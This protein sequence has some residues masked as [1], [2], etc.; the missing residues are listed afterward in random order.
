MDFPLG[1]STHDSFQ[2]STSRDIGLLAALLDKPENRQ[3]AVVATRIHF[4]NFDGVG[5]H[6]S[7]LRDRIRTEGYKRAIEAVVKPGDRV[8][9]FGCGTG[10]LSFFASRAGAEVVYAID[11]SRMIRNAQA[12][13][14]ANGITNIRF[15]KG[16]AETVVLPEKVDVIVSETM[17]EFLLSEHGL[18][19]LFS[20]RNKWLKPGGIVIPARVRL[21]V[22]LVGDP[23]VVEER[24]VFRNRPYGVDYSTVADWPFH[25][26]AIASLS[27]EQLLFES[28]ELA[29]LDFGTLDAAPTLLTGRITPSR[30]VEAYALCGWFDAALTEGIEVGTG[31]HDPK[32]SWS[33]MVFPLERPFRARG[34]CP[35]TMTFR[36]QRHA[37]SDSTLW[38][39]SIEDS[40]DKI[41]MD[42]IVL[43]AWHRR[44]LADGWLE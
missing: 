37:A 26:T 3:T 35:I 10:I 28:I 8:L 42:E 16:E 44:P 18:A 23:H 25:E 40:A 4:M 6:V 41:E 11:R 19:P 36:P 17:G 38:K 21:H 24:G 7:M 34:G 31:P 22:A 30:E 39:W 2:R 14:K 5:V 15:F 27:E 29:D 32:T 13:A 20:L 12:I 1:S 33:Q 9:D 43:P